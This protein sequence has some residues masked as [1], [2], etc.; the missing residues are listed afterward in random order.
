MASFGLQALLRPGLVLFVI[1]VAC[2][3]YGNGQIEFP[4][5][6]HKFPRS[7]NTMTFDG[8][9][10]IQFDF[11][12]LENYFFR[13][14]P[15]ERIQF[16]FSTWE[17][18]GLIF[19]QQ[20][21][22]RKL[23]LAMRGG[24]LVF[25]DDDGTRT[26]NEIVIGNRRF[27]D[28]RWYFFEMKR[29]DMEANITVTDLHQN[30]QPQQRTYIF[31]SETQFILPGLV[32]L[33]G[34][35][36]TPESTD[37]I[38]NRNFQ[39]TIADVEFTSYYS[40]TPKLMGRLQV[41]LST[42][43]NSSNTGVEIKVEEW[44]I[45]STYGPKPRPRPTTTPRPTPAPVTTITLMDPNAYAAVS[46]RFIMRPGSSI[47]LKFR[48]I[49]REGL[50]MYTGSLIYGR[51]FTTLEIYDG[52][53]YHTFNFNGMGTNRTLISDSEVSDGIIHQVEVRY[54]N[55]NIT[56]YLDGTRKVINLKRG[57]T[58]PDNLEKVY[59]G[60]FETYV[61]LPWH[62]WARVGY[63]GCLED[64]RVNGALLDF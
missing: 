46:E 10:Y 44:T 49:T 57:V 25:V 54:Y 20:Y 50:L 36:N 22:G 61:T 45:D 47:E 58:L 34:T 3:D 29:R 5:F 59:L 21:R 15:I 30:Q 39:G 63:Q 26:P 13:R 11:S 40:Q 60:G 53:L 32:Y 55:E 14:T 17:T 43:R 33:G 23:F 35:E 12:Q 7:V 51:N 37:A 1:A 41:L 8:N 48:T 4:V 56:I 31:R 27:D 28:G 42:L 52:K 16:Y 64:V 19:L 24:R 2:I 6:Q 18:D 62:T 38:V 9:A